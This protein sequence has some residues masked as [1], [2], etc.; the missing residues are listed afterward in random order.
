MHASLFILTLLAAPQLHART[1]APEPCAQVTRVAREAYLQDAMDVPPQIAQLLVH[2]IDGELPEVQ[3]ALA[4]LPSTDQLR[5]RQA[6]LLTAV[7]AGRRTEALALL[8]D[9]AAVNE[10]AW[11][12]GFRKGFV[13]SA[14]SPQLLALGLHSQA[15]NESA[16]A[17]GPALITAVSCG[18]PA[19]VEMLLK[20]G[21]DA[22]A[23]PQASTADPLTVATVQGNAP[24]VGLL[25]DH[26]ATSCDFDRQPH[27]RSHATSLSALGGRNGLPAGLTARMHCP[28]TPRPADVTPR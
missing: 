16:R 25:L 21:A 9:G 10:R 8:Q 28:A 2:V 23:R 24:I 17:Y 7:Y 26:G 14:L 6:A 13:D 19:M 27:R 4:V 15:L 11:L 12:P 20:Q 5:W 3:Q 22:R 18:D 1:I